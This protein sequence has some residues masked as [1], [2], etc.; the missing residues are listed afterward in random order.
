MKLSAAAIATQGQLI[1]ADLDFTL[2]ST[3]TL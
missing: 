2:V 3:D 1:G